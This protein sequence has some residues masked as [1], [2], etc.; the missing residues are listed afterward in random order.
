M[1]IIGSSHSHLASGQV[2]NPLPQKPW[3]NHATNG[4]LNKIYIT[5]TCLF[6]TDEGQRFCSLHN[7][8]TWAKIYKSAQETGI[9]LTGVCL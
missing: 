3:Y 6:S 1:P 2:A 8:Y 9:D 5:V 4:Y 7:I